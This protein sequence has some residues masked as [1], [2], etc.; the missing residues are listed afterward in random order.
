MLSRFVKLSLLVFLFAWSILGQTG[1]GRVQGTVVDPT[2]ATVPAAR[3][4]ITNTQTAQQ[5]TTT[6][7]EVGFYNI[8][9]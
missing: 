5:L 6:T 1:S 8:P 4:T 3:V 9:R 7:N 2:G